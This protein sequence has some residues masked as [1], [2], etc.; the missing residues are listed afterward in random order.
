M[1]TVDSYAMRCAALASVGLV[2]MAGCSDGTG[3]AGFESVSLSFRVASV[4]P[5]PAGPSRVSSPQMVAGP[6]LVLEGSNGTLTIDEI[7]VIINEVEL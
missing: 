3:P 4:A 5:A 7:R 1:T 2:A 6:P